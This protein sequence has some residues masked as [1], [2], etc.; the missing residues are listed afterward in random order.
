MI[1]T[2][3][4]LVV[5]DDEWMAEQH[6]RILS[7]AGF[8]AEVA[9]NAFAA[10]DTMDVRLPDAIILD[11]LLTGQNALVLLHE[12]QSHVDLASI[13]VILC[14]NSAADIAGEELA[15]YGVVAVLDK[16]TMHPDDSIAA[17]RKALA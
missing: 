10:I 4:V 3:H 9:V 7:Q 17:V 13:P 15:A 16:T 12:M 11:F 5:E 14:T 6:V 2:P 8:S 1:K